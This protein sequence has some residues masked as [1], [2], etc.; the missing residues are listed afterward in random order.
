MV[1]IIL[2]LGVASRAELFATFQEIVTR[3]RA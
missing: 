3:A 2:E 1:E